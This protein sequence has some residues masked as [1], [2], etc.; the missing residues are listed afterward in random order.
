MR[1]WSTH[2]RY[3]LLCLTAGLMFCSCIMENDEYDNARERNEMQLVLRISTVDANGVTPPATVSE[4]VNSLRIIVIDQGS[5]RLEINE[6]INLPQQYDA[7]KFNYTFIRS[8]YSGAKQVFLIANE[9]SVGAVSFT[10][11]SS[12]IPA[13]IPTTNLTAL[14]DYFGADL[15]ENAENYTGGTLADL[16]N[17]SYFKNSYP[18]KGG[19]IA[20]PYSAYYELNESELYDK[21][22]PLTEIEKQMY[23]VPVAA[24]FDF[25]FT[26]YRKQAACIDDV[27][28]SSFNSHNYLNACLDESEK[29]RTKPGGTERMWWIDWL[30]ACAE[31]SQTAEDTDKPDGYNGKWGWIKN[32]K[33]PVADEDM[34]EISL[35]DIES[36]GNDDDWKLGQLINIKNPP[37]I[38]KGPYYV[39]ES[40]NRPAS[41]TGETGDLRQYYSLTF[42]VRDDGSEDVSVFE[43]YEIDTVGAL[44]R[45]THIII[46]V[47]F[48]ETEAEIYAEIAPWIMVPFRGYV[49]QDDEY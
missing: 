12:N 39:P 42:R 43:D 32:Y 38:T 11:G 15:A 18:I 29:K 35:R 13:E 30:E 5:H 7:K 46:Y 17:S 36:S 28:I 45:D 49:Q 31:G 25:V 4:T 14:L 34:V 23:L 20:L 22:K 41:Y 21:D 40:F 1:F 44:F 19:K 16:L 27:I 9:E 10:N 3:V 33:M 47:E 6:K 48:Y 2:I 8:L 24:K 37:A 26:N